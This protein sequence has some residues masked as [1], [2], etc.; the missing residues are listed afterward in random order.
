M[1]LIPIEKGAKNEILRTVSSPVQK[2]DKKLRKFAK[3][4]RETMFKA[5]G[6][7]I[8]APQVGVN[9]RCFLALLDVNTK[10]ERVVFMANPEIVWK[11]EEM[12]EQEEGCL[13]L[14]G[15][16][17]PVSRHLKLQ[18]YFFDLD[19]VRQSLELED[20]NAR[21]IQHEYDHI[22]GGLYIDRVGK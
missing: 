2:F 12:E 9:S 7:G 5:N 21:I 11:S 15:K 17:A 8:A 13:S 1:A 19:G 20:L 4:M 3:D 14:P 22:E 10:H 18:V 16:Y 6:I